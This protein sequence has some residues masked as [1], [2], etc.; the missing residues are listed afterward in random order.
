MALNRD[1]PSRERTGSQSA[2]A[3]AESARHEITGVGLGPGGRSFEA[4]DRGIEPAPQG[5]IPSRFGRAPRPS[6]RDPRIEQHIDAGETA[7]RRRARST[8]QGAG[9]GSASDTISHRISCLAEHRDRLD[10][11]AGVPI[12]SSAKRDARS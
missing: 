8:G 1:P 10:R 3:G 7:G 9:H 6:R 4:C 2:S 11:I 12:G 5:S